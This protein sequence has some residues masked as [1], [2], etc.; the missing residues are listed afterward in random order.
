MPKDKQKKCPYLIGLIVALLLA[1]C[2]GGG[3]GSSSGSTPPPT[4]LLPPPGAPL[5]RVSGSS[6]Y[7]AN[8]GGAMSGSVSYEDAEVEP[9]VAVNPTNPSNLIGIWQ[10]D[11]WSDGGAHGLVVA[12]SLDN[13]KTWSE[14]TLNLSDC[15]GGTSGNGGDYARASDPWVSFSPNGVAYVISISFSGDSLAPGSLSSVLVSQSTDA[16]ASWSNPATLILDGANAFNDKETITADPNNPNY[17][18]AVWDRLDT[19]NR[20]PAYFARTTNG[21]QSWQ[22]AVS[23]YDPGVNNQTIGNEIVGLPDG[24]IV[25]VFEEIDN[26]SNNNTTGVIKLISSTDQGATWS[27]P[28]SVAQ[29]LSVGTHDPNTG[30]LVRDGGFLPQAAAGPGG[31]LVVVWQDGRFSGGQHDGIALTQSSDD[32]QTWSTPVEINSVPSVPSFTPS[33]AMLADGTIGV[34]YFDFRNN[35]SN[36]DMLI[37]DYW[38]TSSTDGVHWSEQHISGPFDL[39]LAPNAEGLFVGDYQSLAV[40]GQTFVPFFVQTNNQG[41]ANRTDDYALPPQTVPLTVTRNVTNIA[42]AS[43][44]AVNPNAA[45]RQRVHE[46]VM[47]FLRAEIPGWEHI[48]QQQKT[49]PP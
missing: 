46:H 9:Y 21:G 20:G 40:I 30:A 24:T 12:R 28:V 39:D 2:G 5:V 29:D 32:G 13:G 1:S 34:S 16:G 31:K 4:S 15:G 45:F 47:Q 19:S 33:V 49:N 38:F 7:S 44:L 6:P 3:S 27:A 10:Q 8:C 37:T 22:P 41:T 36:P 23:I 48:E 14:Q 35:T 43:P 11:R 18:Y 42:V 26:T 25:D 17:A